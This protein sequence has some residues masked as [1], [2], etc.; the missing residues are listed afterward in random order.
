MNPETGVLLCNGCSIIVSTGKDEYRCYKDA[1]CEDCYNKVN[2]K[3]EQLQK[4]L[5]LIAGN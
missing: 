1:Y 4:Q 3:V 2:Q 5:E